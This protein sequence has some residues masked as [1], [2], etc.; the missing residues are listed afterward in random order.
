MEDAFHSGRCGGLRLGFNRQPLRRRGTGPARATHDVGDVAARDDERLHILADP[1]LRCLSDL[2]LQILSLCR[3]PDEYF[4]TYGLKYCG[5][6]LANANFSHE[7]RKW[8]DSTLVCLQEAIVPKLD[9]STAPKCDCAAMRS[10][11]FAS[12]VACYTK[13]GASICNLPVGDLNEIRKTIG[14]GDMLSGDG[15][16][17]MAQVALICAGSAPDDGRRAT[18]RALSGLIGT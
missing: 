18:W 17:Q 16:Q 13:P 10:H 3:H 1:V 4:E 12:H 9:I 11:A 8:R 15:R 6:F 7:G 2:L 5:A 14:L